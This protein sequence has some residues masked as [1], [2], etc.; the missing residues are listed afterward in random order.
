MKEHYVSY[1]QSR[2]LKRLGFDWKCD[3]KYCLE[4]SKKPIFYLVLA[5]PDDCL[6]APTLS[7]VQAWLRDTKELHVLPKL[8]NVNKPD[9]VCIITHLR[10]ERKRITDNGKYFP[11]YEAA[12]SA[13]I[14]Q[15]LTLPID[16]KVPNDPTPLTNPLKKRKI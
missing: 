1:E 7:Q 3:Y 15:A 10:K 14:T 8:E 9:Y 6:D 11:T 16:L 5:Y 4:L 12:L 2:A 13:G